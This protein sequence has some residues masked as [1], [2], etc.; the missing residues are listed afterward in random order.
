MQQSEVFIPNV[1]YDSFVLNAKCL[2]DYGILSLPDY[3]PRAYCIVLHHK[4]I[5]SPVCT[6]SYG[7]RLI[8]SK[9]AT[10]WAP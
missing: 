10:L 7:I 8:I 5:N 1:N 4:N 6:K 2:L 9:L 3:F